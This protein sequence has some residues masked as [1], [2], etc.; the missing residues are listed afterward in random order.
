MD[1]QAGRRWAPRFF[2]IWIG[3]AFSLVGSALVRFALIWWLTEQTGSATVLTTA[4]MVSM[5]PFIGLAPFSGALVDRWNRRWVM[6]I[7]DAV[8]ALLTALL[9]YLFWVG[10]AQVWHVYAVLFLRSFGGVFQS[11]AMQASTSLMVPKSQ[12][13]RVGGMNDA[14][15][16]AVNIVSPPLGALLVETVSMQ[17]TLAIDL[18]TAVLAIAPLLVLRIPQPDTD[19]AE[20][21]LDAFWGE[22]AEGF[23]YVWNWRGLFFMFVVLAVMRFF[24]APAFSLL[25]LMITEHFGGEAYELAWVNSA[26]GFGFILGGFILGIWGGFERRTLTAVAGL[27]GVGVGSLIFGLIPASALWLAIVVMFFRTMMVPMIRGP[28]MAIF[29]SYVPPN[30]QGRVFT[31]LLSSIS[32]MA[33]VGL[34]LGGPIAEAYGVPIIFVLTGIGCLGVALVWILSPTILYLEDQTEEREESVVGVGVPAE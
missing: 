25:P 28:V 29:Q 8:I 19:L 9:A 3:Q 12:L 26:H 5:L 33:P 4:T 20:R 23:R 2:T 14:L 30:L 6:V 34:M 31:L 32:M 21:S 15:M 24:L 17:G 22:V 13:S 18:V 7:S 1:S 27:V 16:G 11:P 10:T